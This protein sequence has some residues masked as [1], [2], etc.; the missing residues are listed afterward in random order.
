MYQ[1]SKYVKYDL[2]NGNLLVLNE[3][4]TTITV[5]NRENSSV[6]T[7]ETVTDE[8]NDSVKDFGNGQVYQNSLLY[9]SNH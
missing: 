1:I 5:Y 7:L 3:E 6:E 9:F 2:Q 4:G 8:D